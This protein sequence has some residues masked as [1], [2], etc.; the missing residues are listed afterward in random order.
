MADAHLDLLL[1]P[2]W[3]P[4]AYFRLTAGVRRRHDGALR[5][6]TTHGFVHRIYDGPPDGSH[7]HHLRSTQVW[8][9]ATAAHRITGIYF[10]QEWTAVQFCPASDRRPWEKVWTNVRRGN[11]WWAEINNDRFN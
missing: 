4:G 8:F 3:I 11:Q 9:D 2:G 10:D 7:R 6:N 1:P 5:A